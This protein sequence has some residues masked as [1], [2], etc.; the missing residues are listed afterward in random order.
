MNLKGR[1]KLGIIKNLF[2]TI[3]LISIMVMLGSFSLGAILTQNAVHITIAEL[4]R[5][6]PPIVTIARTEGETSFL[7]LEQINQIG[8]LNYVLYYD[9][10]IPATAYVYRWRAF[11]EN[12]DHDGLTIVRF[13]GVSRPEVTNIEM[14]LLELV[15]GRA[16]TAQEIS[17]ASEEIPVLLYRGTA[18]LNELEI[19]DFFQMFQN[20]FY[21]P[22]HIDSEL[23]ADILWENYILELFEEVFFDFKI[24]GLFEFPMSESMNEEDLLYRRSMLNTIF[25]P[26]WATSNIWQTE[27]NS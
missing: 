13:R 5:Q 3:L 21:I 18:E 25:A 17:S 24:V 19:G 11:S 4:R 2:K 12:N 22:Y 10:S 27:W 1:I 6:I 7:T 20:Q 23:P 14:G 9:Y 26:N 15:K 8:Q 16:L